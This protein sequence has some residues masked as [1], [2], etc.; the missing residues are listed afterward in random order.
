VEIP[1]AERLYFRRIGRFDPYLDPQFESSDVPLDQRPLTGLTQYGA[2]VFCQWLTLRTGRLY[3]LPTEA[4]WEYGA[5]AGTKSAYFFGDSPDRLEEYAWF[6]RKL[7]TGAS[8]V[9]KKKPNPWGLYDMYGN[10]AEWTLDGW[11]DRYP[12]G[13]GPLKDPWFRRRA[14]QPFG[15]VRGG[16]WTS[17]AAELRSAA[18]RQEDDT[19][20]R[21]VFTDWH[22][23]SL[24]EAGRK[25]G[26]RV[27]SPVD[28]QADG[29]KDVPI[30]AQFL[31][32]QRRSDKLSREA[33]AQ[34]Q[35][36]EQNERDRIQIRAVN[37]GDPKA[38]PDRSR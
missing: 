23:F 28:L 32:D 26:I 11:T 15:V 6:G 1:D 33:A 37:P 12:D 30:P 21:V 5:R 4:E 16:D 3:R 31:E 13:Q 27:V 25:V 29:P 19:F 17:T 35:Q 38:E 10:V 14:D 7:E 24:H 18:R 8:G 36:E 2:Y 22:L 20:D 34:R 9:G